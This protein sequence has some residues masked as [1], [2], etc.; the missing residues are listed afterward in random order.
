MIQCF[1]LTTSEN[2]AGLMAHL[3]FNGIFFPKLFSIK[4]EKF[5][6]KLSKQQS[7]MMEHL[8]TVIKASIT[9]K[10]AMADD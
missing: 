8:L 6:R 10:N 9:M 3:I 7:Y 5:S 2:D 4:K 1:P